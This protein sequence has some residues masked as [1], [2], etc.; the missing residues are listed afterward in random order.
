MTIKRLQK[1]LKYLGIVAITPPAIL[2]VCAII[3]TVVML[4]YTSYDI[5]IRGIIEV[6]QFLSGF[7]L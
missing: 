4:F 7:A 1:I 3:F 5:A 2:V 6:Y